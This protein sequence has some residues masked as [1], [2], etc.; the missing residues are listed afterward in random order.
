MNKPET[1]NY[2]IEPSTCFYCSVVLFGLSVVTGT[3]AGDW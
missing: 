3:A 1:Q 2:E